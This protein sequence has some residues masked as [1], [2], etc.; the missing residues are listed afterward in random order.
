MLFG[1][2]IDWVGAGL[3]ILFMGDKFSREPAPTAF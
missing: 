1:Q 2:I 3:L